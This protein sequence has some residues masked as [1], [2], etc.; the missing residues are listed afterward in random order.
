MI[1]KLPRVIKAAKSLL[2]ESGP[3]NPNT[4]SPPVKKHEYS[5]LVRNISKMA[6]LLERVTSSKDRLEAQE[7]KLRNA[8][9]ALAQEVAERKRAEALFRLVVDSAPYGVLMIDCQG[10]V[11]MAN[12]QMEKMFGYDKQDLLGRPIETLIPGGYRGHYLSYRDNFFA[13]LRA[14]AMGPGRYRLGLRKDA[15]EFPIEIDLN[16][17]ETPEGTHVLASIIDIT[18]RKALEQELRLTKEAAEAANEAKSAFMANISHEIRTP[19]TGITGMA[20]L[21]DD[22]E[23]T[24]QQREYCEVIRR[25][26]DALLTIINEVLDF[27]KVESGK[28]ELEVIDFDLRSSVEDITALFAQQA[29]DRGIDLFQFIHHD[30][31]TN[32]RGDPG[33]LRQILSNLVGNALKF[34]AEGEVVVR[35]NVVEET[36]THALLRFEITDTGIGI[37]KE[38]YAKLFNV[39]SQADASITRKYGGTGLGLVLCKKFVDL[40]D[41]QIGFTSEIGMGSCFWLTL[42]LLKNVESAQPAARACPD[43]RGLKVLIAEGNSTSRTV[44]EHYLDSFGIVTQSAPDA[45]SALELLR[46]SLHSGG[47]YD[48]VVLDATSSGVN[49]TELATVIRQDP[50]FAATKLLLLISAK[51]GDAASVQQEGIDAYLTKPLGR[52][53]LGECLASLTSKTPQVISPVSLI[54]RQ[55]SAEQKSQRR[56]RILVADD[57]HINQKVTTGLLANM[58]HRADF[59]SNGQEAVEAFKLIPYD[60][61]LMDLQMPEMDGF[62]ASRQIRMLKQQAALQSSVIAITAH[63]RKE[64]RDKCLAWGFDDYV[65]KPIMPRELKAAIE[66]TIIN[67]GSNQTAPSAAS[68]GNDGDVFN[69]AGALTNLEGDRVLFGKITRM[70]LV[71]YPVLLAEIRRAL[72]SEESSALAGAVHTLG[73][74]AGQVG[75][76][77]VLRLA[78]NIE[79]CGER[80]DLTKVPATLAALEAEIES[81]KS[82]LVQQ[83]WA[84]A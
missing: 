56:L 59:V 54:T 46:A 10:T 64:D 55:F 22:T 52:F 45:I 24:P 66:R 74:S 6:G 51:R 60:I 25:S 41:G 9:V 42:K 27:S 16:P 83:G 28:I 30:V 7:A 82:A 68:G 32:L 40:M 26:G 11:I 15:S 18:E 34:T 80:S 44:L 76:N 29:A 72:S 23:L 38:K 48:V 73:S 43:L 21:L 75:A 61:V 84:S 65:S 58:G 20:G 57:N 50:R 12:L 19:M 3:V 78:R 14:R 37:A 67:S 2:S 4:F 62:E 71:Q 1:E 81:V 31:P 77:R 5:T 70:F 39:F 49:G 63:A 17:V 35:V 79:E 33:R 8:N 13:D 53:Q 69:F 47:P 36:P